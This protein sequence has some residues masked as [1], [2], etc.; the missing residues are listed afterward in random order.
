MSVQPGNYR[1]QNVAFGT[2]MDMFAGSSAWGTRI[3]G[4]AGGNNLHQLVRHIISTDM[5]V[6]E[7]LI[8]SSVAI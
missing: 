1:V 7:L 5:Y 8:P 4:W 2:Y 6:H 3:T